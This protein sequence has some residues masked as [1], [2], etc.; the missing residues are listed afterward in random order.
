MEG[1]RAGRERQGTGG[2]KGEGGMG[3]KEGRE[4][5]VMR[6]ISRMVVSKHWQHCLRRIRT[7]L[8][9]KLGEGEVC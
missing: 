6:F 3:G 5:E 8:F 2:E 7:F 4:G 1:G 9:L